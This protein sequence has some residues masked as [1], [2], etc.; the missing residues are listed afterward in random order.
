M[1]YNIIGVFLLALSA[2]TSAVELNDVDLESWQ[3][4]YFG[5]FGERASQ[6]EGILSQKSALL[7]ISSNE[8]T[9]TLGKPDQVQLY[10]R[11][12]KFLVYYIDAGPECKEV[13]NEAEPR[14][15]KVRVDALGTVKEL[16][17][18]E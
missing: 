18:F 3:N 7:G 4:D 8:F 15:L 1:K 13:T 5:C 11:S 2:C 17:L 9:K 14:I 10:K 12:Q 16:I 6:L